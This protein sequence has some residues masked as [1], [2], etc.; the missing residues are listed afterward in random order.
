MYEVSDIRI[1]TDED[2]FWLVVDGNEDDSEPR[3][4]VE[5]RFKIEDA[6]QLYDRV[7]AAIGPW[8]YEREQAF[9]EFRARVDAGAFRCTDPEGE[10][11]A[12]QAR[13]VALRE[14][15]SYRLER[16]EEPDEWR[17]MMADNA[18][19]SRKVAKGE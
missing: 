8:L 16:D 11:I 19:W 6:E 5:Y 4:A 10:W 12:E 2:G 17:E 3:E 7:K 14:D 15:G 1:D 13:V 9:K 18:D